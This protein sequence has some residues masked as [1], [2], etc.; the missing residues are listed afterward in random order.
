[1]DQQNITKGNSIL[2]KYARHPKIYLTL[3]SG[4]RFYS[5]NPLE[6]SGSGELPIYS[7]T[8]KDEL[9]LKTPDALLNGE[10]T[11]AMIKN[12]CPLIENPWEIPQIDVDALI[13]AIRIATYGDKMKASFK[14]PGTE[15]ELETELNLTTMLDQLQGHTF[16]TQLVIGDLTFEL[17]P[18]TYK[19]QT[20]LYQQTLETQRIAQALGN[21]DLSEEDKIKV[22]QEGFKKLSHARLNGISRQVV[23]INTPEGVENNPA[24]IQKFIDDLDVETFEKITKHIETQRKPFEIQAQRVS[25]PKEYVDKGAP[26]ETEIPILFDT[27]N[28]FVSR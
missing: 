12:C 23:A 4:G 24:V 7:M 22:F 11:T 19:Q 18:L 27:S 14:V 16:E 8:A 28:F 9:L 21:P 1:M 2:E 13:I 25:I 5:K 26:K 10:A 20:D 3:P 17:V 6:R 15:D